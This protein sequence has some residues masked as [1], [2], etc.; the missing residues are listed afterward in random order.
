MLKEN[1]KSPHPYRD[2]NKT[3]GTTLL[4]PSKPL[5]KHGQKTVDALAYDNGGIPA[6]PTNF[7]FGLQFP[8]VF[9]LASLPGLTN[10]RLSEK[11]TS[12]LVPFITFT[13][14]V[15]NLYKL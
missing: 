14:F 7:T 5:F 1:K 4:A 9:Q 13:C 15:I 3:R 12:L 11:Q 8:G 10:P 6:R 2:G